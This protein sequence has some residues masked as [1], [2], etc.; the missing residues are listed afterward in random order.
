MFEIKINKETADLHFKPTSYSTWLC[1]TSDFPVENEQAK[2]FQEVK[3]FAGNPWHSPVDG[4]IRNLWVETK[5]DD[6][7]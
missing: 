3:V 4:K 6:A 2:K 7:D 5:A 1:W